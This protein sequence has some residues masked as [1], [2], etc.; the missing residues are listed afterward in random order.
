MMRG[1]AAQPETIGMA[2][3]GSDLAKDGPM[4]ARADLP[5]HHAALHVM[6]VDRRKASRTSVCL[7]SARLPGVSSPR[8]RERMGFDIEM[9]A[10]SVS[11][12]W[13]SCH[14]LRHAGMLFC[15][16]KCGHCRSFWDHLAAG[17]S[18]LLP[19]ENGMLAIS[20]HRFIG[21]CCL[22]ASEWPGLAP[23]YSP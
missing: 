12:G 1:G 7:S 8:R 21:C 16:C 22:L 17:F 6:D 9:A 4:T 18:F 13:V 14:A 5:L 20:C 15:P 3:P 11:P 10:R 2:S 23:P 19:F